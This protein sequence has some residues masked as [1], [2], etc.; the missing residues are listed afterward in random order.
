MWEADVRC[1]V[2]G[3]SGFGVGGSVCQ[4]WVVVCAGHYRPVLAWA[5][6]YCPVLADGSPPRSL[7]PQAHPASAANGHSRF[8]LFPA[9]NPP[10]LLLVPTALHGPISFPSIC[11][12]TIAYRPPAHLPPCCPLKLPNRFLPQG[13][14]TCYAHW[15]GCP[16]PLPS[17]PLHLSGL[18]IMAL[19]DSPTHD[20]QP[21][22]PHPQPGPQ[23]P[24]LTSSAS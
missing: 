8:H 17:P 5:G 14:C 22:L 23:A 19:H 16:S 21:P 1:S 18:R 20:S 24:A 4:Q 12:S 13:I 2:H 3:Q 10:W 15:P 7:Y 6:L 9:P 11:P